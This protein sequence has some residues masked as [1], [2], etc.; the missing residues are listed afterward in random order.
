MED[1]RKP[2]AWALPHTCIG[3]P[4]GMPCLGH[5]VVVTLDLLSAPIYKLTS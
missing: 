1:G 5:V 2:D 4:N 3:G